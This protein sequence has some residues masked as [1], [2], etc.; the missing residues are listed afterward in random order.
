MSVRTPLFHPAQYF[1]REDR[2]ILGKH[3]V[4]LYLAVFLL[5]S[6]LILLVYNW[7]TG[8]FVWILLLIIL[9]AFFP[10]IFGGFV[11]IIWAV[12]AAVMHYPSG[13]ARPEGSHRQAFKD[14]LTGGEKPVGSHLQVLKHYLSG[15]Y[16]PE[17]SYGKALDVTGWAFAPKLLVD[18]LVL[19]PIIWYYIPQIRAANRS[20]VMAKAR[21]LEGGYVEIIDMLIPFAGFV[22][23]IWSVYILTYGVATTHNVS[24]RRALVP[25]FLILLIRYR[26][27]VTSFV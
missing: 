24:A 23:A 17:G 27:V 26:D 2:R 22:G 1:R 13:G 16:R 11:T 19:Y 6:W 4:Y 5:H 12:F 3:I 21:H 14:Y 10:A 20:E 18:G 8:E 15:G 7:W 9:I 25:A